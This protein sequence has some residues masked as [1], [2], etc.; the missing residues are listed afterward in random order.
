[1]KD[2][3]LVR[4]KENTDKK[5]IKYIENHFNIVKF[6]ATA[7]TI[8]VLGGD[9]SMLKAIRTYHEIQSSFTGLN[10]GHIGF[11]MNKVSTSTLEKLI[12]SDIKEIEVKML[13]ADIFDKNGNCIGREHAFNDFYFERTSPQTAK[14]KI[15]VNDKIRFDP[16]TGDGVIVCTSAGSTAYNVSAGGT[17]IPI[18]TNSMVLTGICPAVFH[19]WRTSQLPEDSVVTLEPLDTDKR[20]VRFIADGNIIEEVEKVKIS[21][22]ER[23]IKLNFVSDHDLRE[24]VMNLQFS[25]R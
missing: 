4:N 1:M 17:I 13:Q 21:Y 3:F 25:S 10:Y 14:L 6:P 22:S 15:T 11:L 20:P 19:Y 12:H 23:K 24:K 2:I 7:E 5:I 16:L 18:G 9:G 8:L